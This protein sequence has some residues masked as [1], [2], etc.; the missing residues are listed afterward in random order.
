MNNNIPQIITITLDQLRAFELNPR[1]TR[2]PNYDNIK[3]SI[4]KRGLDHPP[5]VTQ[6]PGEQ[7]YIIAKGGNT[8]LAILNELWLETHDKNFWNI[9]CTYYKWPTPD[10]L[11]QGD[12]DCLLGH[13]AGDEFRGSLTFIERALA[14]QKAAQ[15]ILSISGPVSQSELIQM[16][17]DSGY[18]IHH[19][20][21]SKMAAAINLLLPHIPELLYSGLPKITI[22]RLLTLRSSV[23]KFWETHAVEN[24][25]LFDDIFA[26]AL[27]PF[28]GPQEAFSLENV[29]DEL[30]GIISQTL[31]IDYN[32]VALITDGAAQKRQSLLGSP[33]PVLPEITEQRRYQ[34]DLEST[35][36][37]AD[38]QKGKK[39]SEEMAEVIDVQPE[40]QSAEPVS[41]NV[42]ALTDDNSGKTNTAKAPTYN[43][44]IWDINPELDNINDLASLSEQLA[45]QLAK[46]AGLEHLILPSQNNGFSLGECDFALSNDAKIYWQ[47]LS[48]LENSEINSSIWSLMLMG[49]ISSPAGFSD[50]IVINIAQLIRLKRRL[51]ELQRGQQ[52]EIS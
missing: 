44:N 13:L 4:K 6:R 3:Q 36:G 31:G 35:S 10:S 38:T 51:Y 40:G 1:I 15:I 28:D 50:A 43:D 48:F 22:E 16:L 14:V 47:L 30:T 29:R 33:I 21:Y 9:T 25:L 42:T 11:A 26:A 8:R 32:T 46:N 49:T 19:S 17:N 37:S 34:P 27:I 45:W 23:L 12:L 5:K 24:K 20:V 7:H 39:L 2:N 52:E 41:I 18:I